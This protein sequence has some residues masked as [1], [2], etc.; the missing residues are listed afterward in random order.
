[1]FLPVNVIRAGMGLRVKKFFHD[2][3]AAPDLGWSTMGCSR[4]L[5]LKLR[6]F[7]ELGERQVETQRIIQ[8]GLET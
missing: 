7:G 5:V 8:G 1:M 4:L 3:R 2:E 6:R